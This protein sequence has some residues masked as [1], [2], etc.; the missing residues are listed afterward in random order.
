MP[1]RRPRRTWP[2]GPSR[3]LACVR[4][5]GVAAASGV[6]ARVRPA[7]VA[8][9]AVAV[10][11]GGAGECGGRAGAAPAADVAP[12]VAAT[13]AGVGG[14]GGATGTDPPLPPITAAA[15]ALSDL[16]L[17]LQ[18]ATLGAA[19]RLGAVSTAPRTLLFCAVTLGGHAAGIA[20]AAA[21]VAAAGGR[22]RPP[23]AA[24]ASNAG[25]GGAAIAAAFAAAMR[26]PS[27]VGVGVLL[28]VAGYAAGTLLGIG[29]WVTLGG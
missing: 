7:A 25:G 18:F 2:P 21:A 22:W 5:A 26:W 16:L 1:P 20:V 28:G 3:L 4:R 8:A 27:L 6:G 15:V 19:P 12:A 23:E 29:L 13:A 10:A 9:A 17:G 24:V 11:T 14:A